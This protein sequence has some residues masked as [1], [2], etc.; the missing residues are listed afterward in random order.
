LHQETLA[1]LGLQDGLV[2]AWNLT[3]GREVPAAAK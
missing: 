1:V 3:L 2:R